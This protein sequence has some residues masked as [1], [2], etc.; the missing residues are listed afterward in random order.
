[1]KRTLL[2]RPGFDVVWGQKMEPVGLAIEPKMT[3]K[4]KSTFAA[5]WL[6]IRPVLDVSIAPIEN[7]FRL[8]KDGNKVCVFTE[9][10]EKID[11]SFY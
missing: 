6:E 7:V 2:G 5:D 1:M 4:L 8:G 3:Q 10:T 9:K 11:F